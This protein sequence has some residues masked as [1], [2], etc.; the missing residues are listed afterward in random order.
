M[1]FADSQ[2]HLLSSQTFIPPQKAFKTYVCGGSDFQN[3]QHIFK[4]QAENRR[5]FPVVASQ[6]EPVCQYRRHKKHGFDPWVWKIP[7]KRAW[8][9]TPLF[10]P[11]ESHGQRILAGYSPWGGKESDITEATQHTCMHTQDRNLQKIK[12]LR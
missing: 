12:L 11:G 2:D 8:Q 9:P 3:A 5:G 4:M 6:K 10:L 7:W 1:A